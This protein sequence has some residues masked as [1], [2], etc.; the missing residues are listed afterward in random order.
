M[1]CCSAIARSEVS[2]PGT[3]QEKKSL[4]SVC[5]SAYTTCSD[6]LQ[7]YQLKLTDFWNDLISFQREYPGFSGA[8]LLPLL[9]AA[10]ACI[11]VSVIP[12]ITGAADSL[13]FCLPRLKIYHREKRFLKIS[14]QVV[15]LKTY[16]L[17]IRGYTWFWF[18]SIMPKFLFYL[19]TS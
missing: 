12:S 10:L 2:A 15:V 5:L 11:G 19:I 13:C 3:S 18:N 4:I 16:Y 14:K 6:V 1:D 9:N 7:S 17:H 8:V